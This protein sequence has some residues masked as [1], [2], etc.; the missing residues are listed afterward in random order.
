MTNLKVNK[1][2]Y[3]PLTGNVESVSIERDDGTIQTLSGEEGSILV[4]GSFIEN[5][6]YLPP[7][8][9][10][11]YDTVTINVP[12]SG[13]LETVEVELNK[14]AQVLRPSDGFDG[15]GVVKVPKTTL[16]SLQVS[17]T[18]NNQ[19]LVAADNNRYGYSQV[20]VPGYS[21][22]LVNITSQDLEDAGI[23]LGFTQTITPERIFG[24]D[25]TYK[26]FSSVQIPPA[27]LQAKTVTLS[28][29]EQNIRPT[30]GA[31]GLSE[32]TV[33]SIYDVFTD[34]WT[35]TSNGDNQIPPSPYLGAAKVN[36]RVPIPTLQDT[37]NYYINNAGSYTVD[38]TPDTGYDAM[39][40]TKLTVDVSTPALQ[41]TKDAG[42]ITQN[43]TF[44]ISPSIGYDAM[45]E[46]TGTV[47]VFVPNIQTSKTVTATVNN[48]TVTVSPDN[49]YDALREAKVQVQIPATGNVQTSK[50]VTYDTNGVYTVRADA[51]YDSVEQVNVTVN[52]NSLPNYNIICPYTGGDSMM[53][54]TY[55][56][57]FKDRSFYTHTDFLQTD[58][59]MT[60][61]GIAG[62]LNPPG[63]VHYGFAYDYDPGYPI[64]NPYADVVEVI[65][66]FPI[67]T[68]IAT[69]QAYI[70]S[71]NSNEQNPYSWNDT[72]YGAY[73][74]RTN[75]SEPGTLLSPM[76]IIGLRQPN[77][78]T[79]DSFFWAQEWDD[80]EFGTRDV[81]TPYSFI[82]VGQYN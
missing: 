27:I 35:I 36:V 15:I 72:D 39:K 67:G 66:Y 73:G 82:W 61:Y 7:A 52:T 80:S 43:G 51:G 57:F 4:S 28:T 53:G 22:L 9:T 75:L 45:E 55:I 40:K 59:N 17:L 58:V 44:T 54:Y 2:N 31:Y 63:Y 16:E 76:E 79:Y 24:P 26:G 62:V 60:L 13:K 42:T 8:G 19:T 10:D 18:P 34:D 65:Q 50:S 64:P 5:G 77:A 29:S 38:I 23:S 41:T 70:T 12:P 25:T 49:G 32:V 68:T 74:F 30:D 48:D 1:Y 11:G 20:T 33:P 6:T 21:S 78:S 3:N 81:Y 37:K 71:L 56:F 47:N 69:V 46:V 14:D